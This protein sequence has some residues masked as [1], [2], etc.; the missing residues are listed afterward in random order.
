MHLYIACILE[1]NLA[2]ACEHVEVDTKVNSAIHA[3]GCCFSPVEHMLHM[4]TTLLVHPA[5]LAA[6]V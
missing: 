3:C 2:T 6:P 4:L 1:I 5:L